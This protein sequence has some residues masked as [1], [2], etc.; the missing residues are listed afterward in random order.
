MPDLKKSY[1]EL[2]KPVKEK[3]SR[4]Q[5]IFN[6]RPDT[7]DLKWIYDKNELI[8][9][10][11]K[12]FYT[13]INTLKV[14]INLLGHYCKFYGNEEAY[15]KYSQISTKLSRESTE[16]SEKQRITEERKEKYVSYNE[17]LKKRDELGKKFFEDPFN[18]VTNQSFILLCLYSFQPPI[19]R[20]YFNMKILEEKPDDE[21]FNY[22]IKVDK[23]YILHLNHDKVVKTYG[24]DQFE[25]NETLSALID[26]SL[27]V[28]PRKYIL[29]NLNNEQNP[30]GRYAFEVLLEEIFN[31]KVTIDL[32]RSMY[33]TYFYSQNGLN[34]EMKKLL[35][36]QMRH[37]YT[38]ADLHYNKIGVNNINEIIINQN[39]YNI[40]D[41]FTL[42]LNI[43]KKLTKPNILNNV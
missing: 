30:I 6:P 17:F 1:N 21:V 18:K 36:K 26:L 43:I 4:W 16:N 28:F 9:D 33:I 35:A 32:I 23:K 3:I 14:H 37:S 19:R 13:N 20:E 41:I 12:S 25:F 10:F 29:T 11:I 40:Y 38:T 42:S 27:L 22:L 8:Y 31:K 24:K 5:S 34:I 15:K 7:T 39:N 2:P